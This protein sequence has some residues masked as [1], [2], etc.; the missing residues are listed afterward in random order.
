[1]ALIMF[2]V[3]QKFNSFQSLFILGLLFL[4]AIMILFLMNKNK[5]ALRLK[6]KIKKSMLKVLSL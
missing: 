4:I 2:F 5:T 3:I 1:V 6:I